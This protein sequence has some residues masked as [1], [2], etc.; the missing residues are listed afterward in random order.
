M[1]NSIHEDYHQQIIF[2][3]NRY[4]MINDGDYFEGEKLDLIESVKLYL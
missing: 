3:V 4:I 1:N 2:K